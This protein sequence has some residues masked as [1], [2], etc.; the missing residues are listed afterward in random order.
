MI[1]QYRHGAN[2]TQMEIPG[3][4]ID[5]GENPQQAA[6]RELREETGFIG[7]K[8]IEIGRVNPNPA[9][10]SNIC[11]TFFI[12]D[13]TPG[14]QQL[15]ETEDITVHLVE[16]QEIPLL[17]SSEAIKHGLVVAAFYF[18]ELHRRMAGTVD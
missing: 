6:L 11:Y 1:E 15:D 10:F 12:P 14:E 9:L 5:P 13:V 16:P 3:G 18:Y 8:A 7:T 17:I 2:E 4:I